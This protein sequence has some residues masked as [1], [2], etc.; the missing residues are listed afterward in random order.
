[1]LALGRPTRATGLALVHRERR[2][3]LKAESSVVAAVRRV[4][5]SRNHDHTKISFH[6]GER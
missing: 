4:R 5:G 3:G 6:K 1:M 2:D